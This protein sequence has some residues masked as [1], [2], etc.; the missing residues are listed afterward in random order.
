VVENSLYTDKRNYSHREE[1][2]TD[3]PLQG[4]C[5]ATPE[6]KKSFE[7]FF[8]FFLIRGNPTLRKA[9]FVGPGERVK[10]RLFQALTRGARPDS[11]SRPVVQI[12][13]H[14]PSRYVHWGPCETSL[15][16]N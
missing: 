10:P 15:L 9:Y 11:N 4:P 16:D 2:I 6:T 8:F 13:S 3:K 7:T 5:M 12:S 1:I 14:L